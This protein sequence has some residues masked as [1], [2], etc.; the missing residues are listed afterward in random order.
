MLDELPAWTLG[1]A[2]TPCDGCEDFYCQI[3]QVHAYDCECPAVEDWMQGLD[4]Y[5]T[6]VA[7]YYQDLDPDY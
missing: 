2:W 3:H 7:D 5:T 1:P 4:P 6:P